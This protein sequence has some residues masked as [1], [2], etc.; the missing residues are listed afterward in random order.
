M[1]LGSGRRIGS[2]ES[3]CRAQCGAGHGHIVE[4]QLYTVKFAKS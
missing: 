4:S 1:K 3:E 2:P